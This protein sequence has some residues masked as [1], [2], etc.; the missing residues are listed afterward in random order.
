MP[1]HI[2]FIDPIEKLVPR[3]DSS[4]LLAHELKK[5]GEEVKI[6]YKDE[7]YL[8]TNGV[9]SF[10]MSDFKSSVDDDFYIKTFEISDI[11]NTTISQNDIIHMRLE[12]P[13]D[14]SYMR[15]LWMLNYLKGKFGCKVINDPSKV[16]VNNEKITS[17]ISDNFIDT[18]IGSS[19]E[20]FLEFLEGLRQLGSSVLFKAGR[21]ISRNRGSED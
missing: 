15:S 11:K 7:L 13:F 14:S 10:S 2:L 20:K 5:V 6:L 17:F 3:K 9:N 4:L 12:P 19:C 8:N 18:Y 1:K 16:F 21:S